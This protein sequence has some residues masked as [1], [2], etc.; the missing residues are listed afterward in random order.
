MP[1]DERQ[2]RAAA[3]GLEILIAVISVVVI[4]ALLVTLGAS[5]W[6]Q[7]NNYAVATAVALRTQ[8]LDNA[9]VLSFNRALDFALIRTAVVFVG[10]MLTFLGA[11]YVLRSANE[12]Q[13][14]LS[15]EDK[16]SMLQTTSPGLVMI[17]LGLVVVVAVLLTHDTVHYE[18]QPGAI[19]TPARVIE[20]QKASV[21]D[22][23]KGK[24]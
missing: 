3:T 22:V 4:A 9:A 14:G 2:R 21:I 12:V 20:T 1:T 18:T 10:F 13:Y 17:T 16:K 19:A 7:H 11:M 23:T 24:P 8:P 15:I 6:L 5:I